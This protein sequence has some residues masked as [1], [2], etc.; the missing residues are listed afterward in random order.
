MI[1]GVRKGRGGLKTC[2]EMLTRVGV[3]FLGDGVRR[4][5]ELLQKGR[6]DGEEVD[7]SKCF[8]LSHLKKWIGVRLRGHVIR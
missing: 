4:L 7:A 6:G 5:L 2:V 3:Q 8:D 1:R